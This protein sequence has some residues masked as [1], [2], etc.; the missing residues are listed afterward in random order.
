V[1]HDAFDSLAKQLEGKSPIDVDGT[2]FNVWLIDIH[3]YEPLRPDAIQVLIGAK[4]ADESHT[5]ELNINRKRLVEPDFP[6][7]CVETM[8]RI[9]TNDLPPGARELL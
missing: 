6:D 8:R 4:H 9:I 2:P 5:G 1:K 3:E 7:I